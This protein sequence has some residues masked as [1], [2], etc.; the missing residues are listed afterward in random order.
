MKENR[1]STTAERVAL[2]R[3]AH[4]LLDDPKVLDDPVALRI[5]GEES[6]SAL[7]ADPRR[8]E[9]SRLSPYLRAFMAA[10]SRYAE[11]ELALGVGR[12]VRQYVILGA[13][14]D[15]FA[16]RNPHPEGVLHVFEADHPATQVWKRT[17]LEETG[18]AL[19]ANLTFAPVDFE[20]QTLAEG[21][22]DAG[23]D[24]GKCTFFSWLG[25]TPYLTVETAMAAL[26]FIAQ[27]P[28]G[29]GAV[30][31]YMISPSLMTPAQRQ[32]YDALARHVAAE[33]EPFVGSF[34]PGL[35]E[36]ALRAMGF[37]HVEDQAPEAINA[38]YFKDRADGLRVG[39]LSH[40]MIARV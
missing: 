39:S 37:T 19:P 7:R 4:Q 28:P 33:K 20:S 32:V 40:V 29:S 27:A 8:F 9:T 38:R 3:A 14:L 22:R 6:A 21:L 24:P 30:F 13:G 34:D 26:H 36:E 35:L 2:R 11:D 18:I 17:R 25:V 1:P 5:I 23:Y 15:T 10:R 31:D 12:G 16:Y